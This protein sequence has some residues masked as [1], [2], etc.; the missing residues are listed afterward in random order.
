MPGAAIVRYD[1]NPEIMKCTSHFP[2]EELTFKKTGG[3][4]KTPTPGGV[5]LKNT[6]P[7]QRVTNLPG[8]RQRKV[9]MKVS[10]KMHAK[11]VIFY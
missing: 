9:E 6:S 3:F 10:F 7:G 2:L 4:L 1:V 5:P 11:E 8:R